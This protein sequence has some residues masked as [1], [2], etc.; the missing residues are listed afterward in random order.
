ML[1]A[2]VYSWFRSL[3]DGLDAD[4]LIKELL[5]ENMVLRL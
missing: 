1:F 5:A 3:A 4:R 2:V